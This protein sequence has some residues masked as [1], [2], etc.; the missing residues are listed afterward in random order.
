MEQLL[1]NYFIIT[2]ARDEEKFIEKTIKSVISQTVLPLRWIIVDDGSEDSTAKIA[3]SYAGQYSWIK[4]VVR[5]NR[6]YRN[7]NGGEVEAFYHGLNLY[8]DC[9]WDYLVKLDADVSFDKNY[10]AGCLRYFLDNPKLGIG[11]GKLFSYFKGSLK[12]EPHP[13]FHVRGATKIYRKECW[14]AIG[15]IEKMPGWDTIDEV[16]ANMVGWQTVTFDDPVLVQHRM[17]GAADSVFRSHVNRGIG[18]YCIGYHPL[19]L[20]VKSIKLLLAKPG[21]KGAVGLVYGFLQGHL[22]RISR[23]EEKDVIRYLRRQQLNRLFFRKTIWK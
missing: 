21:I 15:G 23:I 14:N 20:F 11:G 2:P 12:F 5:E 19:Y 6:G 16:K 1:T 13:R 8:R 10:F 9:E 17:T 7:S 4:V 3:L 22:K 18:C